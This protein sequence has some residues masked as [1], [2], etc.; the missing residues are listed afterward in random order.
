VFLAHFFVA[1]HQEPRVVV[2]ELNDWWV[3][4][5][6]LSPQSI[7]GPWKAI[8]KFVNHKTRRTQHRRSFRVTEAVVEK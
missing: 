7:V 6:F 8:H 2:A 4:D 3:F 5:A 1:R